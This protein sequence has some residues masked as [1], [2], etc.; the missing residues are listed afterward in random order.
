MIETMPRDALHILRV[1]AEQ[2]LQAGR[3]AEAIEAYVR[4]LAQ[5]PELP[6]S[7]Y[8]LAYLQERARRYEAALD[9]YR[10]ALDR[11]VAFPEEIHVNRA[12]ILA[13]HLH[14]IDEAT[15][16]LNAALARN[17]RYVPALVN[18]GNIHEQRGER[19]SALEAY[20]RVLAIDAGHALALARLPNLHSTA[21]TPEPLIARL[22]QA[23]ARPGASAA[24]R[25][26]VGFGLGKALDS[27]GAYDE[28]FAAYTAANRDSRAS[29]G[30]DGAR[31]D[32]AG[33]ERYVERL[34]RAFP[35]AAPC[36]TGTDRRPPPIF[37][38]GMFRSGSTLVE[39]ILASH[40]HVTAGGEIDLLPQ[41]AAEHLGPLLRQSPGPVDVARLR[42]LSSRYLD[43]LAAR[44][45]GAYRITDKRP[46]NFLHIG[47]IK[48]LFPD[49]RIVHTRRDPIDNCLSVFFLHLSHAMPYALDL[50]DTAHWYRQHQ[51]LMAHW[52][53]LYGE[54]ILEVDYDNLVVDPKPSLEAL[55]AHC[56]L[57]W[58]DAC[59]SF[60]QTRSIVMT[61]SAWQVRQPLYA[62]SSGRWRHYEHHLAPLR[63]ALQ[64]PAT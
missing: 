23:I 16:E 8:N 2:L 34:I 62:R 3:I 50:L 45:P 47:L 31:Y 4:L 57:A 55:L 22:R 28:A 44:F 32:A 5:H 48:T 58:E 17:P 56:G 6:D 12:V 26:D 30:P 49:A 21:P 61:P 63:E 10:Q 60:H 13:E 37:I 14:R 52:K 64:R 24:E 19:E 41:M 40:S 43:G 35:A 11:G 25:A 9:S 18:L 7:W 42:P 51:R 59:L 1:C 36:T 33:Q 46:D 15:N 27:A 29:A 39:Q 38:C 54:A 20:E 53:S